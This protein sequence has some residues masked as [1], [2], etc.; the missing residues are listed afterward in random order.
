[1]C[2]AGCSRALGKVPGARACA[3]CTGWGGGARGGGELSVCVSVCAR[4]LDSVF[5]AKTPCFCI[6]YPDLGPVR[7]K[8]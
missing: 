3:Q 6:P 5:R 1:M 7:A 4:A 8:K 2:H